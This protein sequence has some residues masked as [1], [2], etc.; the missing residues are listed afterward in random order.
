MTIKL[1]TYTAVALSLMT[2]GAFAQDAN[3]KPQEKNKPA[4]ESPEAA[5]SQ[6]IHRPDSSQ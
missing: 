2:S 6:Y 4:V 3:K 1:I 5:K